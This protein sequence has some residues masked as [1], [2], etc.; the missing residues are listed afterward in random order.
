MWKKPVNSVLDPAYAG[1]VWIYLS[2]SLSIYELLHKIQ[3]T[4][5]ENVIK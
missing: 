4:E 5:G 2:I 1:G 3:L